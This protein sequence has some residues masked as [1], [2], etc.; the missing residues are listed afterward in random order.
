M[1]YAF[2]AGLATVAFVDRGQPDAMHAS[3]GFLRIGFRVRFLNEGSQVY[4]YAKVRSEEVKR[5]D[6]RRREETP[7]LDKGVSR[8]RGGL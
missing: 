7:F 1:D 8:D 5:S 6:K 2:I 3:E 4:G